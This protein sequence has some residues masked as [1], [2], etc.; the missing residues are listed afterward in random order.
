VYVMPADNAASRRSATGSSEEV[1]IS[2]TEFEWLQRLAAIVESSDDA[3]IT[4]TIEGIVTSWNRGAERVFGY[5]AQ[6]MLGQSIFRLA[7]VGGENDMIA[8]LDQIR[9]GERVDHYETMRRR[10]DGTEIAVSLTVSPIRSSSGEIVGASKI[11]RDISGQK[12]AEKNLR[13]AE[14]LAAVGR[15]ASSIAHDINNPLA[16][17]VNLL[18]LLE[19][20]NLSED[21]KHYLAT[22]QRELS[23]IAHITAQALGFYRSRGEPVWLSAANLLDDALM[24]HHNRFSSL[25]IEVS[26]DYDSAPQIF[27]HPGELRQV[28]VNL[29]GNALD[30]MPSGGRLQLRIRK[31][32]DWIKGGRALCIA[33]ADTGGGMSAETRRRLFEPFYT[34]KEGTGSGLGLWVCADILGKYGGRIS[35]RSNDVPGRNGSV[36]MLFLPV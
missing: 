34:T 14:K 17:A 13:I 11:A 26:R 22:A 10:K 33:V 30:A 5:P 31:A 3:I 28:M 18:F 16:A 4:K 27:C 23:R 19:N 12:Q 6:E 2:R 35:M 25:G 20:E 24:L 9:G 21:G 15:L 36:F 1:V 7:C 32:T 8:V 29:V